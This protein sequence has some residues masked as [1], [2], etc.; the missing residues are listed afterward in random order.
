M[1]EI[2]DVLDA[3]IA[4]EGYVI[5]VQPEENL[6]DLAQIDFNILKERF[7]K[8]RQRTELEKLRAF[9]SRKIGTMVRINRSRLDFHNR[10]ELMI[11]AYNEGTYDTQILFDML[12][13][14]VEELRDEEIRHI[15]EGLTEEELAVFDIL[16]K[17]APELT[18][19]EIKNVKQVVK[20]LVFNLEKQQLITLDWRKKGPTRGAVSSCIKDTL[21]GLPEIFEK[22]VYDEKCRDTF[23]HIFENYYDNKQSTYSIYA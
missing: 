1:Q 14:Y 3:S 4:T 9:I 19:T 10:F 8:G 6:V 17:P 22:E 21:D 2:G 12:L 16:M 20:D 5:D 11:K 7:S 15:Q 13:S 18:E 23:T